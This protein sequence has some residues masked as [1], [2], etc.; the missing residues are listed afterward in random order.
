MKTLIIYTS[1]TGFTKKYSEWL[2]D[3]MEADIYEL[4]E[5]Q[6]KKD[7]FF[8]DYEAIV[9]AGWCMA[10]SIVKVKW[11]L[12]KAENWKDKRLAVVCVGGSPNDNPDIEVTL[13]NTLNDEQ[14]KYIQAFY[15]QGG[16]SY[17]KM[18]TASR[19]AMKMFV[20]A[21]KRQQ[22]EKSREMAE[23]ISTSYD[24]S[25]ITYIAPIAAYLRGASISR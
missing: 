3:E 16:F 23:Q 17:E 10:G 12:N 24:I 2:A 13:K 4:K 21:L 14:R 7:G 9:Y 8:A 15:C 6:K 22:D 20:G 25:D 5:V 18:N 1:Q 11:F 19:L